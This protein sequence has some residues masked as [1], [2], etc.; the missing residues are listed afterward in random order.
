MKTLR[1]RLA[2]VTAGTA[3]IAAVLIG[4]ASPAAAEHSRTRN[5]GFDDEYIFA[6]TRGVNDME[7]VHPALKMPLY[8]ITFILDVA[9]LP[10]AV[11]AGFV[12]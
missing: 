9:A 3:L 1:N 6:A 12:G 11:I 2:A 4:A 5:S 8:P 7:G 10:F